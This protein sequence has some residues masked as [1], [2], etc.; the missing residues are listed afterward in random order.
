M[1]WTSLHITAHIFKSW[2]LT[3]HSY[4]L[5]S[6]LTFV[7]YLLFI[8]TAI[9][10]LA[11]RKYEVSNGIKIYQAFLFRRGYLVVIEIQI[12]CIPY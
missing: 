10:N 7:R 8:I 12:W 3:R 2:K 11:S 9:K 4:I 5:F 6:T 1:K